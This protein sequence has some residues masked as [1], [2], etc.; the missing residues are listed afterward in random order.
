[1]VLAVRKKSRTV[2]MVSTLTLVWLL[3][4]RVVVVECTLTLFF[5]W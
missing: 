5:H 2:M 1:M 3:G 4:W